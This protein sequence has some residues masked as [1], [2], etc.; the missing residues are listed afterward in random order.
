MVYQNF[1]VSPEAGILFED[2]YVFG[3]E[4]S[5]E[6]LSI[7]WFDLCKMCVRQMGNEIYLAFETDLYETS[8]VSPF[9][10]ANSELVISWDIVQVIGD[11]G[12]IFGSDDYFDISFMEAGGDKLQLVKR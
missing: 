4:E 10:H 11:D 6:F 1:I 12:Y 7:G 8:K 2:M 5:D 3:A 9:C